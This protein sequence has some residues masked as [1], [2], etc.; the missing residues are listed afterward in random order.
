[1]KAPNYL[2]EYNLFIAEVVDYDINEERI[3][4]DKSFLKDIRI[5]CREDIVHSL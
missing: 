2:P 1:M 4:R 3:S 5:K